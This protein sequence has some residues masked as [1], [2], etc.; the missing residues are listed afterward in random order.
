VEL[1]VTVPVAT[2]HV[3]CVTTV[4]GVVGALGILLIVTLA[5][6]DMQLLSAVLLALIV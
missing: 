5:G 6:A 4:T 2:V 1:T 3:G